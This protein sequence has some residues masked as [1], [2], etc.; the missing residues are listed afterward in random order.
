[1]KFSPAK[2]I[3]GGGAASN[4]VT[5]DDGPLIFEVGRV[6]V[7]APWWGEQMNSLRHACVTRPS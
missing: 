6:Q 5:P 3:A 1:M 4:F 2:S 7:W